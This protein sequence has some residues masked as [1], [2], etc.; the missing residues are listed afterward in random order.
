MNGI[1]QK[2]AMPKGHIREDIRV[3]ISGLRPAWVA[4]CVILLKVP[5]GM[6]KRETDFLRY[7]CLSLPN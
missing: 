7:A 3:G 2:L 5:G 6:E 1:S 4:E